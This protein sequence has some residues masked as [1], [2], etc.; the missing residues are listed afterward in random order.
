M[1]GERSSNRL[2]RTPP[3]SF[4]PGRSSVVRFVRRVPAR[5]SK[6]PWAAAVAR[7]A[8]FAA[9]RGMELA[10]IGIAI[11]G[12]FD[13]AAGVS[14]M[15]HK[16]RSICGVDLRGVLHAMPGVPADAEIR[17]MQDVNAALAGEIARGNAAGYGARARVARH[18]AG[19]RPEP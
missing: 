14:R 8:A 13:Y 4:C 1:S 7:G 10:G 15:T 6:A 2:W 9:E 11:P 19:L 3:G 12:P 18:G 16:F 5:R 17:F